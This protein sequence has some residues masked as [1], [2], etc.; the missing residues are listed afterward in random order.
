MGAY[1][2][3]LLHDMGA[4]LADGLSFGI[5]QASTISPDNTVQEY[6]TQPLWG[7]SMHAPYLHD[8]RAETLEEAILLHGG[9]AQ[10]IRD[11]FA[12]LPPAQRDFIITFL[13]HL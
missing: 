5:P 6:R 8:G 13:E 10:A 7:V 2:D 11:A 3:I 9:E 1:T 4:A 12:S